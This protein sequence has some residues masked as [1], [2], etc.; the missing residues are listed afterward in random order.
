MIH[1]QTGWRI[2]AA[3][4]AIRR[5]FCCLGTLHSDTFCWWC[6]H[7][8]DTASAER[9]GDGETG[10]ERKKYKYKSSSEYRLQYIKNIEKVRICH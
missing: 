9:H 3:V 7:R 10:K 5:K 4:H 8:Q 6:P 2:G 1:T